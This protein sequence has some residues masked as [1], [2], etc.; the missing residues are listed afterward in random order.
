MRFAVPQRHAETPF[1][2]DAERGED[3]LRSWRVVD[4]FTVLLEEGLAELPDARFPELA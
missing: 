4:R 3:M 1:A 2:T